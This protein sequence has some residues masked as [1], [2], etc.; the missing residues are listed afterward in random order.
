MS[1]ILRIN[2]KTLLDNGYEKVGQNYKR[3]VGLVIYT[4]TFVGSNFRLIA[5]QNGKSNKNLANRE[6]NRLIK[7]LK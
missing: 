7:I 5:T 1:K 4:I 2:E 3:V 6:L